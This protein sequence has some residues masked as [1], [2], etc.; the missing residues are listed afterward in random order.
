LS[1][2]L[3]A[4]A[5]L[6]TASAARLA[7]PAVAGAALISGSPGRSSRR[8]GYA[9]ASL[10]TVAAG[11]DPPYA[12]APDLAVPATD[13]V[14]FGASPEE[15]PE[16]AWAYGTVNGS[17][18]RALFEH[19][20]GGAWKMLGL[21]HTA[22]GA[23][24]GAIELGLL[25]G[26]ATAHGS[27]VLLTQGGI[28]ARD[29]GGQPRLVPTPPPISKAT[30][31]ASEATGV[32]GE[33]ETAP[34][35][36]APG[37]ASTAYA[38]ID[39]SDA[40]SAHTA[41]IL[42]A[43]YGDGATKALGVLHYDGSLWTREPIEAPAEVKNGFL[44]EALACGGT[45]ADPAAS[46]PQSCWLLASY[47]AGP[48]PGNNRLALFRRVGGEGTA[49]T[50][51]LAPVTDPA[52]LLSAPAAAEQV[53][54]TPLGASTQMLTA[55]AQGVWVDFHAKAGTVESSV[56]ELVI[57]SEPGLAARALGTWCFA[58]SPS[59]AAAGSICDHALEVP[60]PGEYRSF[61]WSGA[62]GEDPGTRIVTGLPERE[63]LELS[64]GGSAEITGAPTGSHRP[65]GPGASAIGG[66]AFVSPQQGWIADGDDPGEENVY[67][68]EGTDHGGGSQVIEVTTHPSSPALQEESVPFRQPLLALAQA[69]GT[70][71]GDPGAQALAVG[72]EG[73][74]GR[75][76][77][78]E[79]WRPEALYDSAGRLQPVNLRGVAWPEPGRAYAV[80]D[81]GA[82]WLWRAETGLWEPDPAKPFNLIGNLTAIA[83]SPTDPSLGYAVG[84]QGVLL[85]YGK[86]WTQVAEL[87]PPLTQADFTSV[88][89]AGDEALAT[90]RLPGG[91]GESG[92]LA[93]EREGRWHIAEGL[94]QG[95]VLS[96]VA[97]L[98]DGGVVAAGPHVVLE[99]DGPADPW[100][101]SVEPP[102]L[103]ENVSALAAYREPSGPVRAVVSVDLDPYLNPD[104]FRSQPFE[105]TGWYA[106]DV[107]PAASPAQAPFFSAAD[108]LPAGG[109][110]LKETANGWVDLERAAL[111]AI[112]G[113]TSDQPARPDPVLA[114]I[115]SPTGDSGLSVGGQTGDFEASVNSALLRQ[116]VSYR[117]GAAM[118][119]PAISST[120]LS[121]LAL[122]PTTP[123]RASFI[124]A[125][126]AACVTGCLPNEAVG[127]EAWL[128]SALRSA[129]RIA[130]TSAGGLRG[131]LYT[132]SSGG[133]DVFARD[134]AGNGGP[135]PVLASGTGA[136]PPG[137]TPG[138]AGT[139]AYS[140]VS[141][142]SS[143]GPVMVVVLDYGAGGELLQGAAQQEWL[144]A[145]LAHAEGA[146]MPAIVVGNAALDGF[147]L[148]Y[149]RTIHGQEVT[150]ASESKAIMQIL[151]E[152]Q[153]SAY[154][155]DYPGSN[156]KT[157]VE[158]AG[159][160]IPAYGSGTI[161][162]SAAEEQEGATD[163]LGSSGYLLAEVNP[164]VRSPTA[165]PASPAP[166]NA[167][168]VTAKVVP[169]IGQLSLDATDG[170]LLRRSQV[171]L[172]E[173]LARRPPGGVALTYDF[174][175]TT[176]VGPNL[177]DQIPF[178]C[179][180]PNCA[181]EVPTEYTF[182]S[183][184]PDIGNFVAHEAGSANPRQ[185]EL[186]ANK[187]PVPDSH[188]GIFC[189]FNAGTTTVSITTG[190]LTYSEPVAVQAGSVEYPCG[191]VPLL[192]PPPAESVQVQG[193]P[194]VPLSPS[195]PPAT[196]PQV[197]SIA[198]PPPPAPAPVLPARPHPARPVPVLLP[199]IPLVPP[200]LGARPAIVP[201]PGPPAARPI[202]PS[203][204]SQVYQ[205][206]TA[207]Q[208]KREEEAAT[209]LVANHEFS[210]YVA[211]ERSGPGPWLLLLIVLAAGAGTGIG[212][213][214]RSSRRRQPAYA[215]A[216]ARWRA[217]P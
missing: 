193:F 138:P 83:F 217:K 61:A 92:G 179:Q 46:S 216:G 118:R 1:G 185:V 184:N 23:S 103:M 173:A 91:G 44:P 40:S 43:P 195:S 155:F 51:K 31:S 112:E 20:P 148:P 131:F 191:T 9:A 5:L 122:V 199:F 8:S 151:I 72:M 13:V 128:S 137:A 108:P 171:A 104:G 89:F 142:T 183:S 24:V 100:R 145:Q 170:V 30:G 73:E 53:S 186:G 34:P 133:T 141:Q 129:N 3:V 14:A 113:I 59:A 126:Q 63:L 60:L 70:A 11:G 79:G 29:P 115:V 69:P 139:V 97:G 85:Q 96:R 204:T 66:A 109:Y 47:L 174:L 99:R 78:G 7:D 114:V 98:P 105:F 120:A 202:P 180:G 58:P 159:R 177:Y 213:G 64:S 166:C 200:L 125:G 136:P 36:P 130:A 160:T 27:V 45:P 32:L 132:G 168:E 187:L 121:T 6:F 33:G 158:Y 189:A 84:K 82:M 68:P 67:S 210:A 110:L 90:Y 25:G 19:L 162:Y 161:G 212:R 127:P 201:P 157:H 95:H 192:H 80:G 197:Q 28:V 181:Y 55:T 81:N 123:G 167:V 102:P 71:A 26:Q 65:S 18:E 153:A 154:F 205:S 57:H 41:G 88:T 94:P 77:P 152:G 140:F 93:F 124:V 37:G 208:D 15:S 175:G 17:G 135:L 39:D 164:A 38:A 211:H 76:I 62:G 206:A 16:E 169:N 54:L 4:A 2:L 156:V 149:N 214:M 144:R 163:L 86:S 48:S 106:V 165:C 74:I 207:P 50:W 176:L 12:F 209:S 22:A 101:Y 203:G 42:I 117:T 198:P 87:P 194:N 119:F 35:E 56:S 10:P 49:Y 75:Y 215:R 143:G 150:E 116:N 111:P 146:R 107:G 196:N 52:G 182:S 147:R 188:S 21:P 134:L 190:G 178:N 172:F